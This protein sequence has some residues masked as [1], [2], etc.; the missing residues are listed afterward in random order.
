[1]SDRESRLTELIKQLRADYDCQTPFMPNGTDKQRDGSER[2]L[3]HVAAD[4]LERLRGLVEEL[5][6]PNVMEFDQIGTD[7]LER[8]REALRREG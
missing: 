2:S 1:M 4:E 7:W 5:A 6:D 8:A 3:V